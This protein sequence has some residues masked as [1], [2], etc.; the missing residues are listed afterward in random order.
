MKTHLLTLGLA[1]W[2]SSELAFAQSSG[3]SNSPSGSTPGSAAQ[4]TPN[5]APPSQTTDTTKHHTDKTAMAST[6]ATSSDDDSIKTQVQQ[7]LSNNKAYANGHISAENGVVTVN[8]TVA[9]KDDRK[10]VK[11]MVKG[12]T[13]VH[14]VKDALTVN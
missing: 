6:T 5:S 8:G 13:G 2:L 14:K 4:S 12:I 3:S 7:Q 10:Q 1:R 11:E 9:N